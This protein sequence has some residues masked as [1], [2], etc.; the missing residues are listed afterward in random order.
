MNGFWYNSYFRKLS[1]INHQ[2]NT[3]FHCKN[4]HRSIFVST[5]SLI[6][7]VKRLLASPKMK[8]H[9]DFVIYCC[10]N[11]TGKIRASIS[12]QLSLIPVNTFYSLCWSQLRSYRQDLELGPR[13]THCLHSKNTCKNQYLHPRRVKLWSVEM[14]LRHTDYNTCCFN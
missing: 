10:I 6:L 12:T 9:Q 3:Y 8:E 4:S 11:Y 13:C 7:T 1:N 5:I 2:I 14:I